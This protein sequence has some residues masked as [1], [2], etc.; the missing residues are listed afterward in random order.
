MSEEEFC[1]L[2]EVIAA[3][4]DAAHSTDIEDQ[5]RYSRIR[6]E[7]IDVHIFGNEPNEP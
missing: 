1:A 4:H 6:Q 5:V 3:Q 2:M 7:F